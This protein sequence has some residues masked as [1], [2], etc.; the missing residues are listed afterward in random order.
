MR[1]TLLALLVALAA[2]DPPDDA[3]PAS[4]SGV[5]PLAASG[6][7]NDPAQ[8]DKPTLVLVSI[9]GFRWDYPD[10]FDTPAIDSL[11]TSG[12]R[13]KSMVPAFP[14]LTFPNHYS[15][16]TGLRPGN[17]GI[18]G[19]DFPNRDRTSWYRYKERETVQDGR[20]YGGEPIWVA[21]ERNG[22]VSAAFF[23]V[24]TEADVD[25]IEPSYWRPFDYN[26]S[27]SARVDQVLQW[28][29]MPERSRPHVVTLYFED[30]DVASHEYG[31]LSPENRRAVAIVDAYV[32]TLMQG[33]RSLPIADD[34]YVL[35]VSDHG[36][37][38]Y[39][40]TDDP[41]VLSRHVDLGG[42]TVVDGGS[43][44]FLYLETSDQTR[45]ASLRDAINQEWDHG[46]A[47]LRDET[48]PEWH[49]EMESRFP[50]VIVL[51]DPRHAVI[52]TQ[53]EAWHLKAGDHGWRPSFED[54]HGIFIASGPRLPH[55][56]RI[57]SIDNI[58][59]YPL[60]LE[61]LGLPSN[62]QIDGDPERLKSLL[63]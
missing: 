12:V 43:F 28:L 2:C 30:V 15:I 13:A 38:T 41:F 62:G 53:D 20:W 51:A 31:P 33:I 29:G 49:V 44:V 46:R 35:L 39:S 45:A 59:V 34:V 52:S 9:D 5:S 8:R 25:G 10:L 26:I 42:V 50:D 57:E 58:D 22:M 27:G 40:D 60:M 14:S 17:H 61:V 24:G 32:E 56:A 1:L 19:N 47:W 18:V 6:G 54:M 11:V 48:P 21:A 4:P 3:A 55:G 7:I 36:Q 37:S 23:F 63:E 16:A